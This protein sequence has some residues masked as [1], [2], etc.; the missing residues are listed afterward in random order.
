[1]T[2]LTS[3]KEAK[4]VFQYMPPMLLIYGRNGIGKSYAL[5]YRKEIT[6]NDSIIMRGREMQPPK[7][8]DKIFK[9]LDLVQSWQIQRKRITKHKNAPQEEY[10][11][12]RLRDKERILKQSL[13]RLKRGITE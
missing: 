4:S 1:M 13:D 3:L 12:R 11:G 7:Y 8:Y 5:Q 6:D 10:P 9:E 2:D